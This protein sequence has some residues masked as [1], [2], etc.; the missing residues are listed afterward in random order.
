MKNTLLTTC[1]ICLLLFCQLLFAQQDTVAAGKNIVK[2]NL[3]NIALKHYVV[4]YERMVG[5]RQSFGISLG[6][7]PN[8]SLPFRQLIIDNY[9]GNQDTR[10]AIRL[11]RYNKISITPEYRFY[12]GKKA[13]PAGLYI[14]PFARY[15][16]TGI[17]QN[18]S[19]TP[20][21]DNLYVAHVN[22]KISGIGGGVMLGAQWALSKNL[23]LDWFI[24]GPFIGALHSN[25]KGTGDMSYL[26]DD[27]KAY[28]KNDIESIDIPLWD[29][30]A[31]VDNDLVDVKIKGPFYGIRAFGINI[32]Y[33]F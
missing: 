25:I 24:V 3:T 22:G 11:T 12:L 23:T 4:Q 14:A 28:I 20:E 15:M 16:H 31:T 9:G 32:G 21:N 2:F 7:S 13:A 10:N 18:Y 1:T 27:D 29:V 6:I 30:N 5:K 8:V 26:S 19:F 33:R 17:N